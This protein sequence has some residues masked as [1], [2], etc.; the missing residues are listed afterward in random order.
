MMMGP[1]VA[2]SQGAELSMQRARSELR[3]NRSTGAR[4]LIVSLDTR[5]TAGGDRL[6]VLI[7][8]SVDEAAQ[9]PALTGAQPPFNAAAPCPVEPE[10]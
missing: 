5:M 7:S 6:K 3:V 8:S 10:R 2:P 4:L 1:T 9:E